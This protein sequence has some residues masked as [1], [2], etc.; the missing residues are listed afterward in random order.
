[1]G[2][3]FQ[4]A[5][6]TIDTRAHSVRR[7]DQEVHLRNKTYEVLVY[8]IHHRDQV[9]SKRELNEAVWKDTVVTDDAVIRCILE[10]RRLFGDDPKNPSFVRNIPRIGYRFVGPVEQVEVN[11]EGAS[12]DPVPDHLETRSLSPRRRWLKFV[13]LAAPATLLAGLW[14]IRVDSP[15]AR[16]PGTVPIA[17]WRLDGNADLENGGRIPGKVVGQARWP[18]GVLGNALDLVGTDSHMAGEG[19]GFPQGN[20]P[21]TLSAWVRTGTTVGDLT[22]ILEYGTHA[23]SESG[24]NFYL[25]LW[26]D[27][28]ALLA[29]S[30]EISRLPGASRLLDDRW[31]HLAGAYYG[32]PENLAVLY[33]DGAE[34][35]RTQFPKG[36]V[37]GPGSHWRIG[38]MIGT[39][40]TFRGEIDDV[41]IYAGALNAPQVQALY[42]CGQPVPDL[43]IRGAGEYKYFPIFPLGCVAIPEPSPGEASS[44]V[45]NGNQDYSGIQLSEADRDCDLGK[46]RGANIGQDL[47]LRVQLLV[48][49]DAEGRVTQAGPY[50]RARSAFP[51]DGV[52][53]GTAAGFW[54][55]LSS[56]GDVQVRRL[57]PASTVAHAQI[58]DFDAFRFHDLTAEA[59]G[60]HVRVWIDGAP[61]TFDVAGQPEVAVPILPVWDGPPKVGNNGGAAGLIFAAV[62][63]RRQIG[64]QKARNFS[65]E[66]LR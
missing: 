22:A 1:M 58:P 50:F 35:A 39:G 40:T 51:G 34:E 42:R 56:T 32:A 17:R 18:K 8:L 26:L 6:L 16:S 23:P 36:L 53:G 9:V 7:G 2:T 59:R 45:I 11:G 43:T 21:R 12:R 5:G 66:L 30:W 48:P 65:I 28:T 10:I 54:V 38:S 13:A 14:L 57:N 62:Y 15:R 37:T 44:T 19:S 46:I 61:I 60:G 64:G 27:G 20:A 49:R 33:V 47:R 24:R 25:G 41:R 3:A 29:S 31:H 4:V 52:I 63:H 55:M